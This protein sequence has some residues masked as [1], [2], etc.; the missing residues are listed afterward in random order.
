[1]E[2]T[3]RQQQIKDEFL[4]VRGDWNDTWQS[5]LLLDA[6]YLASYLKF[7][8][9]PYTKNHL[10]RKDKELLNVAINANSTH[11]YAPGTRS[12]IRKA[13]AAGASTQEVMEVLECA[14]T[15]GIHAMNIG[16][17]ILVEVLEELGMRDGPAPLTADQE[18]IKQEFTDNRGYWHSFW[19][20][21]LELD[22]EVFEAYT[23]FSSVPWKS[24]TL[25]PKM[26]EFVYIAFD[27]AAT[28]LYVKG[29]RLHI[30]NALGYGA[31]K[32]EILEVME[33][34]SIIGIHGVMDAAPVL[35]A[36]AAALETASPQPASLETAAGIR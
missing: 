20:E 29:L 11:L 9:V 3:E 5:I 26:K 10:S 23:E 12:H 4:R 25:S 15:L 8:A 35:L 33:I 7:W 16:V 28:H 34:A 27:T 36:E 31:T 14:S 19:D 18:R 2:L 30:V 13:L 22:P 21:M 1:M 32:E 17:P 24:G 6:E